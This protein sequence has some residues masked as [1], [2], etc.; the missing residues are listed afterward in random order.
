VEVLGQSPHCIVKFQPTY[1][2][3]YWQST[4]AQVSNVPLDRKV[5]D[6]SWKVSHGVTYT[7]DR[8]VEFGMPVDP[9]CFCGQAPETSKHLFFECGFISS[10]L[11]W[12]QT[13]F[14]RVTPLSP[15]LGVRHLLFGYNKDELDIV[16]PVFFYL[17]NLIKYF[18]WLAR[19]D[20]RFNGV[21]PD[22]RRVQRKVISR[23]N[24]HLSVFSKKFVSPAR[25]RFFHR[26]WNVL[27]KYSP[28][29]RIIDWR[30][31]P[32]DLVL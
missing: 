6:F 3:L 16:P 25:R 24:L 2:D 1:G 21:A 28:D 22:V 27:G 14:L 18:I 7:A 23:F 10:F 29:L 4:W 26:A 31:D 30:A 11:L 8:L 17:L 9:N 20:Y 13:L 5:R 12:A 19:N 32:G 15:T